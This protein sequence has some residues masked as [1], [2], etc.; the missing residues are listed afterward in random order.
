MFDPIIISNAFTSLKAIAEFVK[1]AK[2]VQF[3]LQASQLV[4]EANGKLF[5]VQQQALALQAENQQLRVEIER[6]R[7]F[8]FHHSV[9]W[10]VQPDGSEDGPFCPTCVAEGTDMRLVL[11][12][13]VDQTQAF[14]H[15]H[16]PKSHVAPSK[17]PDPG[18]TRE[19][20]YSIPKELVPENQYFLRH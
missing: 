8:V 14:W 20:V 18:R 13:H 3:T 10:R 9:N 19:P 6:F 16:C 15:L 11:R 7:S 1:T 4:T 2:D 5:D 12:E 17:A